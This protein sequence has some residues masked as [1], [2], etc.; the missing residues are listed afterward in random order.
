VS[1]DA[2]GAVLVADGYAIADINGLPAASALPT[3]EV[4]G[5]RVRESNSGSVSL[6]FT[7]ILSGAAPTGG[8]HAWVS[9][10]QLDGIGGIAMPRVDY[11]PLSNQLVSIAEGATTGTISIKVHGDRWVELNESVT[12]Q[13]DAVDG[14]TALVSR[15]V[16]WI[17]DNDADATLS[18]PAGRG[19][20]AHRASPTPRRTRLPAAEAER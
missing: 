16:G 3:I 18:S 1:A 20:T 14:A 7:L 9:T 19:G 11:W 13:I 8:V 12:L 6:P 4:H 2:G 15:A 17:E 5:S 10:A